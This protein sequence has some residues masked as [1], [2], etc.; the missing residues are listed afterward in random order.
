[1]AAE[2]RNGIEVGLL[3]RWRQIADHHVVDHAPAQ[4]AD[5]SHRKL[6]S[7]EVVQQ[8]NPVGQETAASAVPY[9][10]AVSFNRRDLALRHG[11]REGQHSKPAAVIP[12]IRGGP[13]KNG[14]CPLGSRIRLCTDNVAVKT[15]VFS[16]S[17][18]MLSCG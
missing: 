8:P 9:C 4:R 1:M 2:L 14:T 17:N 11:I 18:S 10:E 3:C 15:T 7:D 12:P 6:L 16:P 13:P 5:L